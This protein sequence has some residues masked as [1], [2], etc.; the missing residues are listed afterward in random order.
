MSDTPVVDSVLIVD[1]EEALSSVLLETFTSAGYRAG[2]ALS[3]EDALETLARGRVD[4]LVVDKNLPGMSGLD[5]IRKVREDDGDVAIVLI[6]G[7]S[8][9]ESAEHALNL[10]VD[11][12]LEKPFESIFG[13][14][15]L[16]KRVL[17]R[18]RSAR[19]Q[20]S[21]PT[22]ELFAIVTGRDAGTLSLLLGPGVIFETLPSG[23]AL[24]RRAADHK[25]DLVVIQAEG[26]RSLSEVVR[27]VSAKAPGATWI[28]LYESP[29]PLPLLQELIEL[30]VKAL[31]DDNAFR[32]AVGEYV[33]RVRAA[34]RRR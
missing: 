2:T 31:Y 9:S 8:S 25:P 28:V 33:D 18:R 12:Y 13:M 32:R 23:E 30:G 11:A 20:P 17:S 5:L 21:A 16:A 22:E 6:T 15:D 19:S 7:Y 1:D 24:R 29:L 14:L 3:A 10:D 27:D 4:L 26:E 34:K